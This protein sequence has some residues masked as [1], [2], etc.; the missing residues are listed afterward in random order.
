MES[1][2]TNRGEREMRS[3][4]EREMRSLLSQD[5]YVNVL[6]GGELVVVGGDLL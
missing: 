3:P 2:I 1:I 6:I 5:V 4:W